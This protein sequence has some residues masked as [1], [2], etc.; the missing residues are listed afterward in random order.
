[1]PD[2]GQGFAEECAI[3]SLPQEMSLGCL[4]ENMWLLASSLGIAFQLQ[5]AMSGPDVEGEVKKLLGNP[6]SA[7]DRIRPMCPSRSLLVIIPTSRPW[8]TTGKGEGREDLH[9]FFVEVRKELLFEHAPSLAEGDLVTAGGLCHD[10]LKLAFEAFVVL[11]KDGTDGFLVADL[12]GTVL[13]IEQPHTK[14]PFADGVPAWTSALLGSAE[15]ADRPGGREIC[16]VGGR[17]RNSR[18]VDLAPQAEPT[19]WHSSCSHR[20]T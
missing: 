4:M 8:R 1:V 2:A 3:V 19:R 11:G 10:R 14:S 17:R 5:S 18:A 15:G 16:A 13:P 20:L 12:R 7:S 6:W 9:L